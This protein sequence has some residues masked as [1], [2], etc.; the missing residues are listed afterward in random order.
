MFWASVARDA[1]QWHHSVSSCCQATFFG[2]WHQNSLCL[3]RLFAA[4]NPFFR[5]YRGS[6]SKVPML[7]LKTINSLKKN[8]IA[9]QAF[10]KKLFSLLKLSNSDNF[11]F[12]Y[13]KSSDVFKVHSRSYEI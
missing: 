7:V 9:E 13:K 5:Q 2:I 8:L 1:L 10:D 4:M 3:R 12:N 11:I 6:I